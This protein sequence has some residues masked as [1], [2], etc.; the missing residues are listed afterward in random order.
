M[1]MDLYGNLRLMFRKE[2]RVYIKRDLKEGGRELT[3]NLEA[4]VHAVC[5]LLRREQAVFELFQTGKRDARAATT[6]PRRRHGV[7]AGHVP[8]KGPKGFHDDAAAVPNVLFLDGA[9]HD[10]GV[11][12]LGE[13]VGLLGGERVRAGTPGGVEEVDDCVGGVGEG[14]AEDA[15][16]VG[17]EFG[18]GV[19][20]EDG[21]DEEAG[22]GEGLE[23][24]ELES[25][26][27]GRGRRWGR[28]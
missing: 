7:E 8:P 16:A 26:V 19:D 23:G 11:G 25:W 14:A 21:L 10:G 20:S 22:S 6:H 12:L 27:R 4:L 9:A 1:K 28:G 3:N 15:G 13:E 17:D 24:V 2:G 18:A 5:A